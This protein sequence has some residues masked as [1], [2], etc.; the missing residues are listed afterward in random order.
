MNKTRDLVLNVLHCMFA[1]YKHGAVR[2]SDGFVGSEVLT[3]MVMKSN[4]FWDITPCSP[5]KVNRRFG[6]AYRLNLQVHST[7][8]LLLPI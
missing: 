2:N 7:I 8:S 3:A 5:L 4:I 1:I 6:G